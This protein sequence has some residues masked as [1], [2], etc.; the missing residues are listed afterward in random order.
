MNHYEWKDEWM[1]VNLTFVQWAL[2]QLRALLQIRIQP[3]GERYYFVNVL[4]WAY[5]VTERQL[6]RFSVSTRIYDVV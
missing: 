5:Y 1:K 4:V 2:L 6:R 3:L